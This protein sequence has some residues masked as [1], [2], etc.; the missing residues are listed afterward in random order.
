MFTLF[1]LLRDDNHAVNNDSLA[2]RLKQHFPWY[3]DFALSTETLI[4]PSLSLLVLEGKGWRVRFEI[5]EADEMSLDVAVLQK[6]LQKKAALPVDF[7]AY[8]KE[9]A[10]GFDDDPQRRFTDDMIGVAEWLRDIFPDA[11]LFDQYNGEV[12]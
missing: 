9:I 11:V 5:R 7:L 4:F 6:I 10:V 1:V 8:N 3:S 2:G 12:W